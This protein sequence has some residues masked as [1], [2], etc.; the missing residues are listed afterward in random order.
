MLRDVASYTAFLV[1]KV[2]GERKGCS[3]FGVGGAQR[4]VANVLIARL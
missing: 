1:I 3:D 2:A 4:L